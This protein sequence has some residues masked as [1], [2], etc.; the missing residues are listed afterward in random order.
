MVGKSPIGQD[1]AVRGLR[2]WESG[3]R[4]QDTQ[5]HK[6]QRQRQSTVYKMVGGFD[7]VVSALDMKK[8]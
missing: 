3:E 4:Q 7:R 2:N 1:K 8:Y 5:R 6:K